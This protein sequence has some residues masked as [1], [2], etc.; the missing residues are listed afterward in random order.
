MTIE[1]KPEF[2]TK[3]LHYRRAKCAENTEGRTLQQLLTKALGE[4]PL[5]KDRY[6][7]VKADDGA[8][9]DADLEQ[10]RVFIN[11]SATRFDILFG[12]VVRY[13]DG[14]FKSM[15]K[16]DDDA[17]HL[18]IEQVAPPIADDGKRREFLDSLMYFAVFDDHVVVIQSSLL[19]IRDCEKHINWFLHKENVGHKGFFALTKEIPKQHRKQIEKADTKSLKVGT[20]LI[21]TIDNK[22]VIDIQKAKGKA[23]T[24][25]FLQAKNVRFSGKGLDFIKDLIPEDIRNKFKIDDEAILLDALDGSDLVVSIEISYK[26]KARERSQD[27]INSFSTALRHMNPEDV[28]I[29]FNNVGKLKGHQLSIQKKLNLRYVNGVLDM[30]DLHLKLRNWIKDQIKLEDIEA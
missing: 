8:P 11:H 21:D 13:S 4:Y 19:Q 7:F 9:D 22:P 14:T 29:D 23:D 18:S 15:V 25:E 16:V 5:V 1:D 20:P 30:E 24:K 17:S 27:I 28:E 2:R 6:Q 10:V 12:E 26:R 3:M